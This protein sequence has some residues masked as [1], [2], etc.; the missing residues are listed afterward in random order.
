MPY[1]ARTTVVIFEVSKGSGRKRPFLAGGL[2]LDAYWL[3]VPR[4]EFVEAA[5]GMTVGHALQDVSEPG[6]RL[7]VVELCGGD[8]GADGCPSDA[9]TV[10]AREQM[11]FAPERDGPDG[12]LDRIVVEFDTAVIE[13]AGK[14]GPARRR[15]T[16]GRGEGAGGW[17][18]AKLH[19]EPRLHHLDERP[20]AGVT[21][22]P[23]CVCGAALD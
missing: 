7:D 6:K 15:I 23:T 21:H 11:V 20:G 9:A 10:R 14:G 12:A 8:E 22:M 17:N 4:Q 5:G 18:A 13:E 1:S 19:L 16:N 3:P 2:G